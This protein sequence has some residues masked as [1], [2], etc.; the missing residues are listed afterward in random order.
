MLSL[1]L[2]ALDED[3][4]PFSTAAAGAE[5]VAAPLE[6]AAW[7]AGAAKKLG[8][9]LVGAA[10]RLDGVGPLLFTLAASTPFWA[11]REGSECS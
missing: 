4:P 3:P 1:G 6:G 11:P 2:P 7:L 9:A 8:A 10:S 5:A